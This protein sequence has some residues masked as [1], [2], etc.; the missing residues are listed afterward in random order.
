MF[1]G[2]E[3]TMFFLPRKKSALKAVWRESLRASCHPNVFMRTVSHLPLC[4]SVL[5]AQASFAEPPAILD[6]DSRFHPVMGR[7]GIV[8]SQEMRASEIG[9]QVLKDGGN[10][11]D[12][13][14]AVAYALSVTLPK[15]G[16]LGGGGFM[17]LHSAKDGKDYAFDFREMAPA[18]ATRDMY[19]D[20]K[21][22]V[23]EKRARFSPRSV[24]VPGTVR[25]L[26]V[27]HEKFGSKTMKE[28]M[29][30]AIKLAREG[31]PVTPGLATDLVTLE[32]RLKSSPEIT[33]VFYQQDGEPYALGETLVQSDLAWSLEQIA[34]H[35]EGA[36]YQG[37]IAEKLVDFMEKSGGLI[38]ADDLK[39]YRVAEREPVR[40]T[41]RGYEVVSMPPPSSGGVHLI[42]ML[43]ILENT[44]LKEAGHN[45]A[46][47]IHL[48]TE[49]MKYAYADRSAHLGDPDFAEVPM[50]WLT[51]KSYGKELYSKIQADKATPSAEIK[52]GV[53]AQPES[54]DTTHFSI[55][56][57]EGNAVSMTYTL[58]FSFGSLQMAPGTGFLLNNEMDDFSAKPGVP[59]GYGLLGGEANAIQAGKRPLSS[60]TPTLVLKEGKPFLVTGS[61]GGSKIITSVL[62][63]VLNVLEFDMNIAEAT[64]LS[65][66]HHQWLPDTLNYESGISVDTLMLLKKLGHDPQPSPTMG[67]VQSVMKVGDRFEGYSDTRRP[68]AGTVAF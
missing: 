9:L 57:K 58:N 20:E 51:S 66:I 48:L 53:V 25:G 27:I 40:G 43:N 46:Y 50:K 64:S 54:E 67:S 68:D 36:F 26:S 18:A 63:T 65:R 4:L 56:D 5:M 17:S 60:M 15:A 13:A 42:Q 21:G 6:Y 47:S 23:D 35:G 39:N 12:S 28:L 61:P 30:P 31:F 32:T 22:E 1:N 24:G 37:A 19:L 8:S 59:N 10:A 11:V 52:P 62:Q 45:S 44:S 29:Q 49:T 2:T 41:Y 16:N 38:T 34:E 3:E 33:K 14:V 55:M 7:N